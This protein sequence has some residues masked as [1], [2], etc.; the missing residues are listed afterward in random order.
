MNLSYTLLL[1]HN[2]EYLGI[3]L[4]MIHTLKRGKIL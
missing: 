3:Y 2:T 1:S 4:S